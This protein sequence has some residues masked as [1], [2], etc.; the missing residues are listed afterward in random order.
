MLV[1]GITKL[2]SSATHLNNQLNNN[3]KNN[4]DNKNNNNNNNNG[5]KNINNSGQVRPRDELEGGSTK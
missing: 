5:D 1:N 4:N 2:A 3:N